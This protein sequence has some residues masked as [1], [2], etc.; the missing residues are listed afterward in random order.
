M[1]PGPEVLKSD[2]CETNRAA[3]TGAHHH[4]HAE[5]AHHSHHH[6]VNES[7]KHGYP[8]SSITEYV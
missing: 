8:L 7:V 5:H 2:G 4:A 6:A 3:I 1:L